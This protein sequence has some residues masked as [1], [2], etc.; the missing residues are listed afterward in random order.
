MMDQ[1]HLQTFEMSKSITALKAQKR[2]HQRV[3]VFLDGEYAFGLSRIVA[4]WLHVGQELS[5]EKI[6]ELQVQDEQEIAYQ[7][8]IRLVGYRMR[9]E[10]E[11]A[12]YLQDQDISPETID[13]VTERLKKSGLVDDL[14]FAQMWAEN[15]R[16]FRPRSHRMLSIELQRKG[17][18]HE[19]I[20]QIFE[21]I[22]TDDNL[23][24]EAA[25]KQARKYRHL[26]WNDFRRKLTSFLARRGFSY[27]TVKPIVSQLW[28]ELKPDDQFQKTNS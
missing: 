7:K 28:T 15:R 3:S 21:E 11:I 14:R 18:P 13:E 2:N 8:A 22:P 27:G 4:A 25:Q 9:S 26:E 23:A 5:D 17:I 1:R 10:S 24:Y 19:I 6:E 16:E 12:R 20:S